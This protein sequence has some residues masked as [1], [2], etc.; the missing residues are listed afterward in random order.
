MSLAP[1]SAQAAILS[2]PLSSTVLFVVQ[3]SGVSLLTINLS[4]NAVILASLVDIVAEPLADTKD[5]KD[6]ATALSSFLR[7]PTAGF[8]GHI[9][10]ALGNVGADA[11]LWT[12]SAKGSKSGSLSYS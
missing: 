12:R 2:S 11:N 7:I 6:T 5:I 1:P 3:S 4:S 10:G 9:D 8:R